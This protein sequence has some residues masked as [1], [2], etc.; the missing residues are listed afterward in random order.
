MKSR[1]PKG[2]QAVGTP[3]RVLPQPSHSTA[4][5]APRLPHV[6]A[7]TRLR[8]R[9]SPGTC[10][11]PR[12]VLS[13][14]GKKRQLSAGNRAAPQTGNHH[15][16]SAAGCHPSSLLLPRHQAHGAEAQRGESL[17]KTHVQHGDFPLLQSLTLWRRRWDVCRHSGRVLSQPQPQ[18]GRLPP[19]GAKRRRRGARAP[20]GPRAAQVPQKG[21]SLS[22]GPKPSLAQRPSE[23]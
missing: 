8:A 1:A 22:A 18:A 10:R 7:P 23:V 2:P 17:T 14:V 6:A 13:C 21:C 16:G 19:L 5:S 12:P 20:R 4:R 3:S 9:S 11:W 15:P